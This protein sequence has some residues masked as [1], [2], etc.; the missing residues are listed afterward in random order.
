VL[1]IR[2]QVEGCR[3]RCRG[4]TAGHEDQRE[5]GPSSAK[6]LIQAPHRHQLGQNNTARLGSFT[7]GP[8]M[9]AG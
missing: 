6:R 2:G 5:G 8:A 9:S 1:L 4:E 7:I 3:A